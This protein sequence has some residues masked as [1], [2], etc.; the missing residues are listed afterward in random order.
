MF[1]KNIFP[2][3]NQRKYDSIL[4]FLSG[5]MTAHFYYVDVRYSIS[6]FLFFTHRLSAL[7]VE[8]QMFYQEALLYMVKWP[9]KKRKKYT[10]DT[11]RRPLVPAQQQHDYQYNE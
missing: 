5:R 10:C 7:N 2:E 4:S 1:K 6:L 9:G 8:N 3:N 11:L